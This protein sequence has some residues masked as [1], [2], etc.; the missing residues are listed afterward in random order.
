MAQCGK[1]HIVVG[2]PSLVAVHDGLSFGN[3][4][5]GFTR[6]IAEG[7]DKDWIVGELWDIGTA[8]ALL[9]VWFPKERHQR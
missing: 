8:F 9:V 6:G 1:N 7:R 3:D 4:H 2:G 5:M